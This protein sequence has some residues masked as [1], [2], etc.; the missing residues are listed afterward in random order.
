MSQNLTQA[1]SRLIE[2]PQGW[3]PPKFQLG[4]SV[5]VRIFY[6]DLPDQTEFGIISGVTYRGVSTHGCSDD[7]WEYC[8]ALSRESEG[9][10]PYAGVIV[11]HEHEIFPAGE[12]ATPHPELAIA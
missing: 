9:W 12:D 2:I 1:N 10:L 3:Q 6:D 4:Q 7:S 5:V 8:I 11:V